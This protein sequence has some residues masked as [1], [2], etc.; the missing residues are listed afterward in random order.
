MLIPRPTTLTPAPG[1]FQL[2]AARRL[3]ALNPG[4]ERPAALLAG[5]L[6][7][8]VT[9]PDQAPEILLEATGAPGPAESCRLE[10]TPES[11]RLSAPAEAGLFHD[12]QSLRQL[13]APDPSSVPCLTL[14][15]A[16]AFDPLG[17]GDELRVVDPLAAAVPEPGVLGAQAQL[18]TEFLPTPTAV[19]YAAYPRLHA[20]AEAVWSDGPREFGNFLARLDGL[21]GPAPD[22]AARMGE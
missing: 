6:G 20:F 9:R 17:V 22:R 19:R 3:A 5:Y 2:P 11:V 14:E 10:I 12:V 8:E 15:D 13:L 16:Y 18:W 4:A 21:G 1:R 7:A